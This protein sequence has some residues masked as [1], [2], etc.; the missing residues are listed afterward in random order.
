MAWMAEHPLLKWH[1]EV[2]LPFVARVLG[3][4]LPPEWRRFWTL[5]CITAAL[6]VMDM[7]GGGQEGWDKENLSWIQADFYQK[8]GYNSVSVTDGRLACFTLM[9]YYAT[10]LLPQREDDGGTSFGPKTEFFGPAASQFEEMTIYDPYACTLFDIHL[11]QES[12]RMG[13]RWGNPILIRWSYQPLLGIDDELHLMLS[14]AYHLIQKEDTSL[15]RIWADIG[16]FA[17]DDPETSYKSHHYMALKLSSYSEKVHELGIGWFDFFIT[18]I[19]L[20]LIDHD[21]INEITL[22]RFAIHLERYRHLFPS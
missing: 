9:S 13:P 4:D 15:S 10:I 5:P 21:A 2:T 20:R 1:N 7:V 12:R 6:D 18:L 8:N 19:S 14:K 11:A 3:A 22:N 16:D 17:A